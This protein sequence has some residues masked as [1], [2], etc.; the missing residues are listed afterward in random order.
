MRIPIDCHSH[1]E[2]SSDAKY[3][4]K[5]MC[6][7]AEELNL[8]VFAITDHCDVNLHGVDLLRDSMGKSFD[9]TLVCREEMHSK[10]KILSG[11][12]LNGYVENEEVAKEMIHF[13]EYDM[14][15]GSVHNG[16]GARAYSLLEFDKERITELLCEYF[17][18]LNETAKIPEINVIAHCT[19]PLRYI[20]GDMG[21]TVNMSDYTDRRDEFYRIIIQQGTALEVNSAG[22]KKKIGQPS[23]NLDC[24]IRYR[25][26]GGELLTLGSDAHAPDDIAYGF[27]YCTEM[28]QRAGFRYL[29]YFDKQ[30]PVFYKI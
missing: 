30:K 1:S 19:Y 5:S 29:T 7:R 3:T 14:I 20:E 27:D 28:I 12:E 6:Q 23:P 8:Q 24:L 17:D 18:L 11:I 26:L 22:L 10:I 25:E 16:I 9:D 15:L 13:K 2:H 21:M 4:V